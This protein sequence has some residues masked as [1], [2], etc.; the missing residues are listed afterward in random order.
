MGQAGSADGGPHAVEPGLGLLDELAA[1]VGRVVAF[2]VVEHG[3]VLAHQVVHGHRL[4][5]QGHGVLGERVEA[6]ERLA[7]R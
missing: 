2:L 5:V 3:D 1:D 6:E 4:A 7:R